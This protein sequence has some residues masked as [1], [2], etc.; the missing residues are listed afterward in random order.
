MLDLLGVELMPTWLALVP[1]DAPGEGTG[2]KRA[3]EIAP[4]SGDEAPD[5][6]TK[7]ADG[8]AAPAMTESTIRD[9]SGTGVDGGTAG[10][11]GIW[12]IVRRRAGALPKHF[13]DEEFGPSAVRGQRAD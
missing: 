12:R 13:I 6:T 3:D 9:L 11:P 10:L 5:Q 4:V 2:R 8:H 1:A 7:E